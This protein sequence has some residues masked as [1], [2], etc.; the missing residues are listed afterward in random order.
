MQMIKSMTF[1]EQKGITLIVLAITLI[2]LLI[3]TGISISTAVGDN[4]VLKKAQEGKLET[5]G[6]SVQEA[7]DY[8][9]SEK[10][11]EE[12]I[13][14]KQKKLEKLLD[15]LREQRLLLDDEID[16]INKTG[17]VTIGSRTIIFNVTTVAEVLKP[18]DYV[19][20]VVGTGKGTNNGQYLI[21]TSQTGY[22][23]DQ[24]FNVTN[25]K[26]KWRVLYD[27]ETYGRV[28]IISST[29]ILINDTQKVLTLSGKDGYNN[30]V[31][32]LNGMSR[33][34]I[35]EKYAKSARSVGSNPNNPEGFSEYYITKYT[36]FSSYDN[37]FIVDD[38]FYITDLEAINT[39]DIKKINQSYWLASR[40]I[41]NSTS[42]YLGF[43]Y[44]YFNQYAN[45]ASRSMFWSVSIPGHNTKIYEK[46]NSVLPI[47]FLKP[48][49]IAIDS[50]EKIDGKTVWNLI[51]EEN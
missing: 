39:S 32:T 33:Y 9:K 48:D 12:Y 28:E 10:V 1:K 23:E 14:I 5:R 16:I 3:L 34:Y 2:V 25:Y 8:W 44:R 38:S 51:N 20:Y 4:G 27:Y 6:A 24:T 46:G 36:G 50:G 35:N 47:I 31:S 17:K 49:I 21:T 30:I 43:Y 40:D 15:E 26:E 42:N 19:N 29:N 45:G 13:N 41:D 22:S 37:Q 18:G 11:S 7:C